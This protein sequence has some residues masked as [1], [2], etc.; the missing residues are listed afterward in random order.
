MTD[1]TKLIEQTQDSIDN[2]PFEEKTGKPCHVCN[3]N[4]NIVAALHD[5][6]A[7]VERLKSALVR[8]VALKAYK[9]SIGKDHHYLANQPA[10]WD[11]AKNALLP[12]N[13]SVTND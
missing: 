5:L 11:Q 4:K 1:Y 8:L 2:C 7:E 12:P 13:R 6:T 3:H 10:A 9:D